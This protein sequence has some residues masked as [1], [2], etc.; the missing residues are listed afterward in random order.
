MI[1]QIL[2]NVIKIRTNKIGKQAFQSNVLLET[3]SSKIINLLIISCYV[4]NDSKIEFI[5]LR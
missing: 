4:M 2:G 1:I 3:L 5:L